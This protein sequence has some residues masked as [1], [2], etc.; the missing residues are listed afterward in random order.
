[1]TPMQ[2]S[3]QPNYSDYTLNP[4]YME[5]PTLGWAQQRIE[6]KLNCGIVAVL[7][8]GK[9]YIGWRLLKN[10]PESIAFNVY[11]STDEAKQRS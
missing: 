5:N 9:V 8:Q 1:M 2:G 7:I 3:I 11:R 10:D 4:L 6:E